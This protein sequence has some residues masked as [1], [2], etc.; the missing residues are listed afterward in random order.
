MTKFGKPTINDAAAEKHLIVRSEEE[1]PV[2]LSKKLAAQAAVKDEAEDKFYEES[3]T[4]ADNMNQQKKAWTE[5]NKL[6]QA[7]RDEAGTDRPAEPDKPSELRDLA[8]EMARNPD[9]P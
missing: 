9:A 3:I 1:I 7:E 6:K 2:E 4:M 8:A 5:I